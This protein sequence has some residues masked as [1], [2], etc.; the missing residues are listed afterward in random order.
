MPSKRP[1]TPTQMCTGERVSREAV[2][3]GSSDEVLS[4]ALFLFY[5]V[6]LGK[7]HLSLHEQH[8]GI[9]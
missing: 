2:C 6:I 9:G 5:P 4:F 8:V 3:R 1:S 7:L